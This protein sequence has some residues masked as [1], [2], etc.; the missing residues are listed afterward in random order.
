MFFVYFRSAWPWV[1]GSASG[2]AVLQALYGGILIMLSGSDS[3]KRGEGKE[4]ILWAIAG[5]LMIGF[6]GL[7]LSILNPTFY[8]Q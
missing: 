6:S 3:G 4:K 8:V 1:L 2:I 7:I 5:L